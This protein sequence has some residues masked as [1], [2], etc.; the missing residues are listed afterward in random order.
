MPVNPDRIEL[1][2][3]MQYYTY[4]VTFKDLPGY[5]YYGSHK[6]NGKSYFGSP[7]TWACFWLLFEPEVQILQWYATEQEVKA[8]EDS[9][10]LA[11]WN[12]KYSL[13]ENAGGRFSEEAASRGGKKTGPVNIRAMNAH[14]NTEAARVES[15]KRN[16]PKSVKENFGPHLSENGKKTGPVNLEAMNAHPNTRNGKIEGSKKGGDKQS[17]PVLCVETGEVYISASE[18]SRQT[19]TN[20]GSI[21]NGCLK[22]SRAGGMRWAYV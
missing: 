12:N 13:N 17:R 3:S 11:T 22:G 14:P 5:F 9:I 7:I 10:L 20:R 16:G 2:R 19:G 21:S 6:D 4:K 8:A 1:S 15:G 18:A